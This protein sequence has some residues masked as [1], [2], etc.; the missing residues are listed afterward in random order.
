M[1]SVFLT[2]I[3]ERMILKRYAKRT[4]E[5]YTYWIK[6][7]I[8]FNDKRHPEHC[9]NKEGNFIKPPM[10]KFYQATHDNSI[11]YWTAYFCVFYNFC[12]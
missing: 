8:N 2:K 4:I 7:F 3:N 12:E 11:Q 9:H 1:K 10:M 5:S 6:A